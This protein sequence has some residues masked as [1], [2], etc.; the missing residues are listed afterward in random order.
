MLKKHIRTHEVNV[1]VELLNNRSYELV[2]Q[3]KELLFQKT[4]WVVLS[5][6]CHSL[7]TSKTL[8]SRCLNSWQSFLYTLIHPVPPN[9]SIFD[10]FHLLT[11]NPQLPSF[12]HNTIY[13]YQYQKINHKI[14][15]CSYVRNSKY[16]L[17]H[18]YSNPKPII[19]LLSIRCFRF[20]WLSNFLKRNEQKFN[21]FDLLDQA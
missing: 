8:K 20:S 18:H 11:L 19:W 21:Y 9:A 4:R 15:I 16:L 14:F 17:H 6:E 12:L 2:L 1:A 10:N 13:W 7:S 5:I 3:L